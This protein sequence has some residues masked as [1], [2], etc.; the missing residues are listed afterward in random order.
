MSKSPLEQAHDLLATIERRR[1]I[2]KLEYYKPYDYQKRFHNALGYKTPDKLAIQRALIAANKIGKTYCA[3]M[4]V[5][6][7]LTGKYPEDW[8]GHKFT[9]PVDWLVASNTNE[10]TRDI[11]QA[12]LFGDPENPAKKGTGT[13]PLVC[14][15][16]TTGKPG[17]PNAYDIVLVKH[18][19]GRWSKVQF[20]AYEQGFKKFMGKDRDGVWLDEEPP[21]DIWSQVVRA[22]FAKLKTVIML[23]FTPE[24]GWTQV[25]IS[26]LNQLEEGQAVIQATWDD[27]PHMTPEVRASKLSS[28]PAHE[29]EMREK[30]TPLMGAGKVFPFAESSLV[31]DPIEIPR[32]WPQ[33]I[34][35]D[36]GWDHPFGAVNIA[37][38]RDSDTIYLTNDYREARVTPAIHAAA[39]L[40]WGGWKPVAWPHDGLN[41]EKTT[42]EQLKDKYIAEGLN[43]LQW[44]ATNPP[45]VNQVEGEGGNSPEAAILDMYMRMETGR[46][47]VFRTCRWWL[48]EYRTYHR[49]KNAKLV[50]L[51]EDVISAS[52]HA[53]MMLRHARTETIRRPKREYAMG[54]SNW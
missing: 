53:A 23:T 13:V 45:Q 32:H 4:E 29:R 50:K 18:V 15:G 41:T 36:Y 19:S 2:Y 43:F 31:I 9:K 6:M 28:I 52:R 54:A 21:Q 12:E 35:I 40:K 22:T 14:I 5:A 20:K 34:G 44:K 37:W 42:G 46:W 39:I 26:F 3:A 1:S 8:Q 33:I 11:C 47:K 17:V 7:H 49:D 48:E 25:V 27:A 10:T 38:D 30:G 24:E 16:R 51:N